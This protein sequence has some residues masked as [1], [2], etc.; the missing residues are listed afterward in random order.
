M[1]CADARLFSGN[2][3]DGS[4][5]R[6]ISPPRSE[7]T[8]PSSTVFFVVKMYAVSAIPTAMKNP[9]NEIRFNTEVPSLVRS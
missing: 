3:V 5:I 1:G 7:E 2:S 6:S 9:S 8:N 4:V